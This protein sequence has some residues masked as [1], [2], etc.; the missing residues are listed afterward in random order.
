M[1]LLKWNLT[2]NKLS[3]NFDYLNPVKFFL[4]VYVMASVP[5]S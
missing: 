2:C 1:S 4:C 3:L 5:P